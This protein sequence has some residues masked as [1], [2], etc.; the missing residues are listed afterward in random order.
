MTS[1]LS[2]HGL[3]VLNTRPRE[4][5]APLT[6]A[7]QQAGGAVIELP[8]LCIEPTHDWFDALPSLAT[9]DQALFISPNAVHYFCQGLKDRAI[10]WPP[11][12]HAT[13]IGSATARALYEYGLPVNE[14][15]PIANSE[16]VLALKTLL[17]VTNQT[18]LL[19][20]GIGGIPLIE[21]GLTRRGARVLPLAVYRR[22]LPR[23]KKKLIH[24]LWH[25]PAVDIIL[26]T[27]EQAIHNIMTLFKGPLARQ[28]LCG[29][30]CLVISDRLATVADTCGITTCLISPL[31]TIMD[32]LYTYNQ[33][34]LHD[35][36]TR[37]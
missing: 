5:S 16:H 23:Y 25:D 10:T 2:L 28:W 6:T 1:S 7:I 4:S 31:D 33:G 21:E 29:T 8:A 32:A 14:L 3:C 37:Y 11:Q 35:N 34:L 18:I 24:S 13:A 36:S 9:I 17:D 12:L 22:T 19:V 15:P 30:P 20:K 26:F 27:S